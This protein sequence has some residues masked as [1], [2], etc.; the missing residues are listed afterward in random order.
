MKST[1]AKSY[2]NIKIKYENL[3]EI[4]RNIILTSF[5]G[6]VILFGGLLISNTIF[7]LL[8]GDPI[9]DYCSS[10]G[11]HGCS[12]G[13]IRQ[14]AH[15]LGFIYCGLL[16]RYIYPFLRYLADLFTFNLG[17]SVFMVRQMPVKLMLM[18]KFPYTIAVSMFPMIV[19]ISMGILL[20]INSVRKDGKRINKTLQIVCSF[21]IL[22][23]ILLRVM[24]QIAGSIIYE[25]LGILV[26]TFAITA[27]IIW[28]T[29]YYIINRLY[30]KSI[31]SN[32]LITGRIIGFILVSYFLVDISINDVDA[33]FNTGGFGA[34]LI[35]SIYV[36]DYWVINGCLVVIVIL[37]S[38]ITLISNLV[39]TYYK[40][41]LYFYFSLDYQMR[42]KLDNNKY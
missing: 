30:E 11:L 39:F 27:F 5:L 42:L 2:T 23:P 41:T 33:A 21:G 17:R 1:I 15:Q 38:L 29:R 12:E 19:G 14:L 4:N 7:N 35:R 20:G 37:F 13:L 3:K 36:G 16:G 32:T 6:I 34:L 31:F 25:F 18:E 40:W 24:V 9:R 8:P 26:L 22:L 28:Q 10:F